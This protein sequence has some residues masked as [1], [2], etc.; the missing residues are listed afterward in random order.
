MPKYQ[1]MGTFSS[2][3]SMTDPDSLSKLATSYVFE[4]DD[5]KAICRHN[6][7]V[8]APSSRYDAACIDVLPLGCIPRWEG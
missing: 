3:P 8:R 5:R 1:N 6:A 4:G 7:D 2:V